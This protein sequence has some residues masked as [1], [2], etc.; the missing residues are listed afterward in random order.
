MMLFIPGFVRCRRPSA[1][2]FAKQ[3][4]SRGQRGGARTVR[5]A[6]ATP[7]DNLVVVSAVVWPPQHVH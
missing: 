3:R 5:P 2:R 1:G 4:A 6:L 7:P